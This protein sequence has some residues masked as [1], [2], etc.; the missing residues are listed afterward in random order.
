MARPL[1][2]SPGDSPVKTSPAQALELDSAG[3][4]PGSGGS[5]PESSPR[6]GPSTS[7]LKTSPP[8]F[9][10]TSQL[11]HL[12][13]TGWETRQQSLFTEHSEQYSGRWPRSGTMQHGI[14]CPLDPSAALTG[15]TGGF[16]WPT[17]C[18]MNP[19]AGEPLEEWQARRE[20]E[21]QKGH[22]GNG[23]G[24]PLGVAVRVWPTPLAADCETG[25]APSRY[26]RESPGLIP[27]VFGGVPS[28]LQERK[29][30]GR[31]SPE[32]VELLMGFPMGW[33]GPHLERL[34]GR[35]VAGSEPVGGSTK[36][37]A[38]ASE[39]LRCPG[40]QKVDPFNPGSKASPALNPTK[41]TGSSD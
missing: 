20:R 37:S 41:P 25:N 10:T 14:V 36:H 28:T 13:P 29:A 32:W 11:C 22:N 6:P 40:S 7:C 24:M 19:S 15:A 26:K 3:R 18:A 12:G 30:L 35:T 39:P 31:I 34:N 16:W 27:A 8:L 33:T 21:K 1:F 23:F 4:S 9:P 5:L 17:P 38:V 2:S